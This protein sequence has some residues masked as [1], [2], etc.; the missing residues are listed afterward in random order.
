[1]LAYVAE[2][3]ARCS[4]SRSTSL[5]IRATPP[6]PRGSCGRGVGAVHGADP[7]VRA[8]TARGRHSARL[9]AA[10]RARVPLGTT[11]VAHSLSL[12]PALR[13]LLALAWR[14]RRPNWALP[15][16]TILIQVAIGAAVRA[17]IFRDRLRNPPRRGRAWIC[18][19]RWPG[20][21]HRH[22]R[23]QTKES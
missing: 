8:R 22:G 5:S 11:S 23:S 7:T 19:G 21:R 13:S 2:A 14:G 4:A 6:M 10:R 18:L 16:V 1:L 15:D 3:W 20:R 17:G 12:A 9:L